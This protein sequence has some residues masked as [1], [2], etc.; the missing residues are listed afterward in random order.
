MF[1]ALAA[2]TA[3]GERLLL[4]GE[5]RVVLIQHAVRVEERTVY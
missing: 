2:S 4:A 3:R 1:M 5:V